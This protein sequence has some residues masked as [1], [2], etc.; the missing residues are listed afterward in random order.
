[1]TEPAGDLGELTGKS[2][3]QIMECRVF[4]ELR[5]RYGWLPDLPVEVIAPQ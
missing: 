4:R 1:M 2:M 3:S 5:R